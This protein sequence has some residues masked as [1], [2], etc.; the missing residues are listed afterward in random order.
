MNKW[1]IKK[2]FEKNVVSL[3]KPL[4]ESYALFGHLFCNIVK[5]HLYAC[6]T[7]NKTSPFAVKN[8]IKGVFYP[9]ALKGEDSRQCGRSMVEMLGVLAVVGVLS[10][11]ALAGYSRA[12][13][14]HKLNKQQEQMNDI[15]LGITTYQNDLYGQMYGQ[16]ILQSLGVIEQSMIK[17]GSWVDVFNNKMSIQA[18]ETT[19]SLYV[20]FKINESENSA[21]YRQC[22]NLMT[23]AQSWRSELYYAETLSAYGSDH[24]KQKFYYGDRYCKT[25]CLRDLSLKDINEM[26][27]YHGGNSEQMMLKIWWNKA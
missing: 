1:V 24:Q 6:L 13:M 3:S 19:I 21:V 25:R 12:M 22:Q 23:L 20:Y 9:H 27:A 4:L 18:S 8:A 11:G 17:D 5:L 2:R 15:L 7:I 26:C 10:A 16:S 14:Q